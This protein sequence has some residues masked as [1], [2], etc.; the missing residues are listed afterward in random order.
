MKKRRVVITGLGV[1]AP[2]GIGKDEFWTALIKGRS[3]V[4]VLDLF[5]VTNHDCRIAA[6]IRDFNPTDFLPRDIV[7]RSDRFVH[8]GL[9]AARLAV[10]DAHLDLG[11]INKTK[12]GVFIGSG[13]GGLP[14]HEEQILVGYKKGFHRVNP[15][16]VPKITP[17]SVSSYVAIHL[18]LTG[19]NMVISTACASGNYAIAEAF[20]KILSSET[21]IMLTGGAEAPITEFTFGA[22]NAMHVLSKRNDKPEAASRPFDDQ[23]DGFVLGEGAG[24]I[25][26]EELSHA[27]RRDA[28]IYAEVL[29]YGANSG[30][31]HM[32]MPQPNGD[33][34][35]EAMTST[36]KSAN[37]SLWEVDY[38]NAHGTSTIANDKSETKAIKQVFGEQ[39]YRI[40][41]SS[42][43]SMIGHTIGA[44]GGIEAVA[45]ALTVERNIIPPTI[46]YVNPD[47]D[48][49]LDY[50]PNTGRTCRVNVALSNS[51]GFGNC[52]VCVAIGKYRNGA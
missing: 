4:S 46:N 19:P 27:I 23:R 6:Q 22:Y 12:I 26:L 3:G 20:N 21:D 35:A 37:L 48:C 47:P 33:D 38:I 17:N 49:N 10:E 13:L 30:A 16:S 24:I 15:L 40:P 9:A 5:D 11:R 34:V 25:V 2:N 1:V 14:F 43:K 29:G 50:V 32:V 31:Y 42:I 7:R 28:H 8:L 18:G 51:F 41:V 52:N 45:C 36:L 39:A 44:A